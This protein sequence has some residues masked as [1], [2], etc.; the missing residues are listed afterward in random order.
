MKDKIITGIKLA[1]IISGL[2]ILIAI[3]LAEPTLRL[4]ALWKYIWGEG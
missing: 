2:L 3:C 1:G 4:V